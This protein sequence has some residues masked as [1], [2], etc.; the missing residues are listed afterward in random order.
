MRYAVLLILAAGE[1]VRAAEG[2]S[3][4]PIQ[5][6]LQLLDELQGK[7]IKEGEHSQAQYEE[8]VDW[9]GKQAIETKHAIEDVS[10]QIDSLEATEASA[11]ALIDQLKSEIEKLTGAISANENEHATAKALREKEHQD[12]I[13]RDTDLGETVDMLTRAHAVLEKNLNSVKTGAV[14]ASLLKLTS[15]LTS[16]VDASFVSLDD[17]ELVTSLI[18]KVSDEQTDD[19]ID[20]SLLQDAG[21]QQQPQGNTLAYEGSSGPILETIDGLR[22]KAET[23]RAQAQKEEVKAAHSF[24]MFEQATL[25]ELKAQQEQL[26]TAKKRMNHNEEIKAG[27]EGE[28]GTAQQALSS[29]QKYL[30][31]TQ[32]QCMEKAHEF[33]T[34]ASE[35]AAEL[36]VLAEA[37]KILSAQG[38]KEPGL[39]Q[40]GQAVQV[41]LSFAQVRSV[42]EFDGRQ[43]E[44]SRYLRNEGSR[45]NSWVLA[46]VADKVNSDPFAKVKDMITGMVEKL[47]QE[48]AE[49]SEH[50]AWCDEEMG[51]TTKSLS[52]KSDRVEELTTRL[53]KNT[54]EATKLEELAASAVEEIQ[55]LDVAMKEAT[56]MRQ[57]E[58]AEFQEKKT[59]Y[60]TGQKACAAA[61][62]VLR[63][64]YEGK[65]FLQTGSVTQTKELSLTQ[66]MQQA[67]QQQPIDALNAG[68]GG[69]GGGSSAASGIVGLLEV[70][71]SDFSRMLAECPAGVDEAQSV[72]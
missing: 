44:A 50:K 67:T 58:S 72:F 25:S 16:V 37:K 56:A 65:S 8:F 39:L 4:G 42:S 41:Q 19:G 32:A 3:V 35:R 30:G 49:E 62:K 53:E 69:G 21:A 54:A 61:I 47:L 22:E 38:V 5:K 28:L 27:A 1:G 31:D 15:T 26:D 11:S 12:F 18:Q 64:Y 52:S 20:V 7:V 2:T 40:T 10:E 43:Q 46:Q 59:D 51:K 71:E 14:Q 29:S 57:A 70:A 13:A 34:Q 9:C 23:S 17:K 45:L 24:Q 48:Q 63:Q 55:A 36:T 66:E 68:D 60:E 33:E 6:V